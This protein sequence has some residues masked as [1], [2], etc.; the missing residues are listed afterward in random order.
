M[1]LR[2]YQE[3]KKTK[4][5][6]QNADSFGKIK[7]KFTILRTVMAKPIQAVFA[8]CTASMLKMALFLSFVRSYSAH[9]Q[10]VYQIVAILT[11]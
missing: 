7:A 9:H 2:R 3:E 6:A 10:H 4:K 8:V 1:R 11:F 5:S